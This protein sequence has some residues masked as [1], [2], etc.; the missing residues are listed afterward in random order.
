RYLRTPGWPLVP[1]AI[2]GRDNAL[3]A[4][5]RVGYRGGTRVPGSG[6]VEPEAQRARLF[7]GAGAQRHRIRRYLSR[8]PPDRRDR[9]PAWRARGRQWRPAAGAVAWPVVAGACWRWQGP[10]RRGERQPGP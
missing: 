1:A 9:D 7:R 8:W 6:G 2:P 5:D 3:Q 10:L 4:Q